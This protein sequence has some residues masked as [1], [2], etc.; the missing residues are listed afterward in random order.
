MKGIGKYFGKIKREN[1]YG[2]WDKKFSKK[3]RKY[4]CP[5]CNSHDTE[6]LRCGYW[7]CAECGYEFLVDEGYDYD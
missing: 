1:P 4:I 7:Y 2:W 5:D 3:E 6:R